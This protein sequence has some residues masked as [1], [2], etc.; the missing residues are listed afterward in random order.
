MVTRL[1]VYADKG[2]EEEHEFVTLDSFGE[3]IE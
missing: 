1:E 3:D 2:T